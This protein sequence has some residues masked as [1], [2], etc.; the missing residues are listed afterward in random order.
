MKWEQKEKNGNMEN[1]DIMI[2]SSATWCFLSQYLYDGLQLNYTWNTVNYSTNIKKK[3]TSI[4]NLLR[5]LLHMKLDR[6]AAHTADSWPDF[7][8]V[9]CWGD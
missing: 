7:L 6:G 2:S 4:R 5:Q 8:I 9:C 1:T 3:L